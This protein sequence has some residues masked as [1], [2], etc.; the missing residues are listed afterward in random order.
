MIFIFKLK[1][2]FFFIQNK[3][4]FCTKSSIHEDILHQA[5]LKKK[6]VYFS[7]CAHHAQFYSVTTE[8]ESFSPSV[9]AAL[10]QYTIFSFESKAP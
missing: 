2:H 9:M 7:Y 10:A 6:K 8:K 1:Q 3:F 4:A 5:N